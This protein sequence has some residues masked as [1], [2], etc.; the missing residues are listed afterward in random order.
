[1]VTGTI[2]VALLTVGWEV[3]W[4]VVVTILGTLEIG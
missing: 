3:A 2:S 1:M 4:G